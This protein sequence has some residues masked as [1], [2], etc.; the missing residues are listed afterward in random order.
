MDRLGTQLLKIRG[1]TINTNT[2][3][4]C[5]G[6]LLLAMVG[7]FFIISTQAPHSLVEFEVNKNCD[8]QVIGETQ[9]T[10]YCNHLDLTGGSVWTS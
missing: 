9:P 4:R 6:I 3:F 8:V 2:A 1:D 7:V 5:Y 10:G